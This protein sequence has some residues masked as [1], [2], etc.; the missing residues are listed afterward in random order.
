MNGIPN[1]HNGPII[2]R[3]KFLCGLTVFGLSSMFKKKAAAMSSFTNQN[4]DIS[5]TAQLGGEDRALDLTYTVANLSGRTVYL[6]DLLH[7]E[8]DGSVFP[9]VDACYA[10]IEDGRLVFSRQIIPVPDDVLV[11]AE[12]IPF[13]TPIK[14]DRTIE[15]TVRQAVPVYP[16]TPYTEHDD[17]PPAKGVQRLDAYFRIGYFLEADGTGDLAKAAPTDRG[18]VPAFDPFPVESQRTLMVGPIGQVDVY[19]LD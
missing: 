18:T 11:E 5:L 13:V 12:N 7:A 2:D 14:P 19:E 10:T 8:F 9:L 6:F 17:I 3:R 1:S 15:K 4:N 16:W